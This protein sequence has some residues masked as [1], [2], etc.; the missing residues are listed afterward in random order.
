MVVLQMASQKIIIKD[1]S[2]IPEPRG[3]KPA[4][5]YYRLSINDS[6]KRG[7]KYRNFNNIEKESFIKF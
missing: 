4:F 1:S 7:D 5:T 2:A 3:N 6:Q